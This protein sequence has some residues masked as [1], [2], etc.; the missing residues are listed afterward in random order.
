MRN[1]STQ[2]DLRAIEAEA[3]WQDRERPATVYAALDSVAK[4]FGDRPAISFQMFS[5]P[6][7]KSQTLTW[8]K[9]LEHVTQAANLFHELGISETDTVAYIL[10][11]LNETAITLLGGMTAGRVAPI[12]PLL[13]PDKL[14]ALL[15]ESGAKA[16]VTLR[17]FPK[18]DIAQK[19]SRALKDAPQVE[20]L[21]ELDM[22]RHVGPPKSWIIP[23][24]RPKNPVMHRARILDFHTEL[25][26]QPADRLV[27]DA[28]QED[29]IAALFHT[30]GTTGMPKL[31]S[32]RFSGIIYNGW[33]GA[34]LLFTEK[35][36]LMCP[37]PLFHV[38]AAYP[39]LMCCIL[40]GA[41][42]VF[43][44]PQGYRGEGVFDNFWK[45]IEKWNVTFMITV[46]TALSAL[47]SRKVDADISSL[48]TGISGSA[49]LPRELYRRFEAATGVQI[50]EG[51][52][53]T[54]ATCLVSCNPV[55]GQKK[56]GSV[57]LPLPYTDVR[58][59][60]EVEETFIECGQ[61]EVGEICIRN[62]G[63]TD[64]TYIDASKNRDLYTPD[65]LLRTG[66][67]GR[68]DGDGYLWI[69]GRQK[70][71][72]I[73][74]GHNIDPAEIEEALLSHPQVGFAG[75]IGQPDAK[76]GELPCAYVECVAGATVSTE[77]LHAHV[78][79]R[80]T[81]RAAIPKHIEILDSLPKTAIGKVFK[82]DLR[83][84]A[85]ARVLNATLQ[86]AQLDANV[87]EVIEDRKLGLLARIDAAP[88]VSDAQL[89]GVLG[90]F[91]VPYQRL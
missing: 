17:S 91:A 26:R 18:T 7:S 41:H 28:S 59:L 75:A 5:T 77:M 27:F 14:S 60:R 89:E 39:I 78:A 19:V 68:L 37:L 16:V 31:A 15:R 22:L 57:G 62:P 61:D 58:I 73:R 69:T 42:V 10:P 51:Y 43:P 12:N 32:H 48:R 24:I 85:I 65:G 40:S 67:L 21:I 3:L 66:D 74:S 63:V 79:S 84:M 13:D 34:E 25:A 35:D 9:L 52:G 36:V 45:L 38:F 2:A 6:G 33:L 76:A 29:R 11:T 4:R 8:S 47:V 53:L 46:P 86:D 87:A 81:E 64:A 49:A 72:I 55:D 23:L 44:T 56:I 90:H 50:A 54:E 71:L 82:P 80:L 83:R 20:T 1:F 88:S 70:D 30:G